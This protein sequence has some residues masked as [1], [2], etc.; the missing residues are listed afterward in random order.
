MYGSR[1]GYVSTSLARRV[2]WTEDLTLDRPPGV[3]LWDL[4]SDT[5]AG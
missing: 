1:R 3:T 5:R 4:E 2:R